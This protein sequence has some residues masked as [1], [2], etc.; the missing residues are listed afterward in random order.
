MRSATVL[1]LFFLIQNVRGL[2]HVNPRNQDQSRAA[3]GIVRAVVSKDL[4]QSTFCSLPT[5]N[6]LKEDLRN[7]VC[8]PTYFRTLTSILKTNRICLQMF[9]VGPIPYFEVD[10]DQPN[11]ANEEVKQQRI[12]SNCTLL[13]VRNITNNQLK[14][15]TK[16]VP[17][18]WIIIMGNDPEFQLDLGHLL[19]PPMV[20]LTSIRPGSVGVHVPCKKNMVN[21]WQRNSGF[22][23]PVLPSTFQQCPDVVDQIQGRVF[24]AN[25][26]GYVPFIINKGK[27]FDGV[28]VQIMKI[29]G[30]K[31]D[32]S[33]NIEKSKS[34]DLRVNGT[35]LGTIGEVS[36]F[37]CDPELN[38]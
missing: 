31:L 25:A 34:W 27:K 15:A 16:L 29:I 11:I 19:I 23:K 1:G 30:S 22:I 9:R 18:A 38:I 8:T 12:T 7:L 35:R 36:A 37:L 26:F 20:V 32:F 5:F 13:I 2:V 6:L 14:I 21:L 3:A 28:D 33:L 4:F 10:L 24:H 17:L